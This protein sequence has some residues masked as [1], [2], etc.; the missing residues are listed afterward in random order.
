MTAFQEQLQHLPSY[1][2]GHL[3]LTLIALAVGTAVSIP[4]GIFASQHDR[5]ER[6]ILGVAGVIQTI[7]GLAL[8]AIMVPLLNMIG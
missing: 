6:L 8:L 1:L 7:P 5:L 4:L 3:R 2:G